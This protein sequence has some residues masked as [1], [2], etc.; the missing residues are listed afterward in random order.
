MQIFFLLLFLS[1]L[2]IFL[3]TV[4]ALGREDFI[5]LRKNVLM[6]QLFN[7]SFLTLLVG[8]LSARI[9]YIIFNFDPKFIHP[10]TFFLFFYFPGL[11]LVGGALGGTIFTIGYCSL[12]HLPAR[13][14]FD[15]FSLSFLFSL[16]FGY[17][18]NFIFQLISRK[19]FS[20]LN[21]I[22]SLVFIAVFIFLAKIFMRGK[23]KD[24]STGLFVLV[25]FSLIQIAVNFSGRLKSGLYIKIEDFI[26]IAMFLVS[27]GIYSYQQ[28]L[29]KK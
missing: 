1:C 7:L 13:R 10:M 9:F 25:F 2:F 8:L 15:I 29:K 11:S 27:L 23:L 5:I 4:Y 12:R 26:L 22:V 24:G 3:F 16:P 18:I 6:E 19:S 17:I 21:L 28:F 14:I 20:S